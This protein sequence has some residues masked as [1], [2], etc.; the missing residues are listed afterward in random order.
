MSIKKGDTVIVITGKDKK[1]VGK[2]LAVHTPKAPSTNIKVTVEGV[3]VVK[4]TVKRDPQRGVE[5]GFE[6]KTLPIS[7]SNVAYYCEETKKPAKLG[8]KILPNGEKK[9]Y[10]KRLNKEVD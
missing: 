4:K 5:G 9:R 3:N 1:K 6:N 10:N 2:V 7:M 8:A